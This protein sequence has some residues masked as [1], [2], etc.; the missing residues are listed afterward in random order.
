M[1]D[2]GEDAR[3]EQ[4]GLGEAGGDLQSQTVQAH[5]YDIIGFNGEAKQVVDHSG[6]PSPQRLEVKSDDNQA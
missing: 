6:S 3:I 1:Q 2:Y 4:E 5:N